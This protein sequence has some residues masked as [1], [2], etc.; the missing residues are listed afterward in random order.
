MPC[1]RYVLLSA[2]SDQAL[3][4]HTRA[5][6]ERHLH[7]CPICQKQLQ[8]LQAL[9]QGLRALPSPTLEFDLDAQ[10]ASRLPRAPQRSRRPWPALW[11]PGAWLPTGVTAG[12]ALLSGIWM[13]SLLL[14]GGSVGTAA[15][16]AMVRVFDPVPPGGLCAAA[17]LCRPTKGML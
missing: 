5:R 12:L 4:P 7:A 14:G 11:R 16:A 17:E 2:Y 1:P 13:G 9:T 15:P 3:K 8:E 6:F 10:W